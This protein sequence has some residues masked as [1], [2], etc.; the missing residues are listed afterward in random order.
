MTFLPFQSCKRLT[1][2]ADRQGNIIYWD[3]KLA[4]GKVEI[5]RDSKV[6]VL[7]FLTLSQ[8]LIKHI[9]E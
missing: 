6:G 2:E 7:T 8:I 5:R 9:H 3:V 1:V 4:I